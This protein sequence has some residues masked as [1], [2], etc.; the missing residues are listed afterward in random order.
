[1]HITTTFSPFRSIST[2]EVLRP[3]LSIFTYRTLTHRILHARGML[4]GVRPNLNSYNSQKDSGVCVCVCVWVCVCVRVGASVRAC[5]VISVVIA[6]SQN[7]SNPTGY[8]N[9]NIIEN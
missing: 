3:L 8:Q 6:K 9:H 7:L 2:S 5:V 4:Q 1:M